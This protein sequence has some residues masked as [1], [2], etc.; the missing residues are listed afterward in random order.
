MNIE[1]EGEASGPLA[2]VRVL[3]FSTVVS[4][5]LATQILGDL[6]ADVIKVEAPGGDRARMM[7]PPFRNGVAALYTQVNR[8]KRSIVLDLKSVQG[9]I[10]AK[11]LASKADVVVENFRPGVA[12]RLGIGYEDLAADNTGLIYIDIS[13]FGSQGPYRDH[14]A[15]DMVIQ[16]LSGIGEKQ[17]SADTPAL[18]RSIIADKVSS[19]TAANAAIAALYARDCGNG[20]GQYI[21]VPMMDA[22][23]AFFLPDS[24]DE[25]TFLPTEEPSGPLFLEALYRAWKTADG[26]IALM[27]VEDDQFSALCRALERDDLIDDPRTKTFLDRVAN[28]GELFAILGT[29][30]AK[31][32]T[33]RLVDRAR[34]FGAPVAPVNSV[35][36]FLEDPHVQANDT[37]FEVDSADIGRFRMVGPGARF[38]ETPTNL[39][40]LPPGLG[41]GGDSVLAEA[42]FDEDEISRLRSSGAFG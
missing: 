6:G 7:G 4:G 37:V 1:L 36:D 39:R 30:I 25:H 33:A 14:P 3:D 9:P 18:V 42:G 34:E 28:A 23:A 40:Q 5:P 31:W 2:G 15:Y 41:T 38:S 32:P 12:T 13:G 21:E 29:E 26:H 35:A 16:A 17:G 10:V 8:N 24:M 20:K 19:M 22:F 11:R 27:V